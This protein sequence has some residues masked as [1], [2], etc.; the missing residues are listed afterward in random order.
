[1]ASAAVSHTRQKVAVF[2]LLLRS[3]GD[4]LYP[5][6]ENGKSEESSKIQRQFNKLHIYA[7]SPHHPPQLL[8]L[9][10]GYESVSTATMTR[11]CPPA[12]EPKSS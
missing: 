7:F 4:V 1:M 9:Q 8:T 5:A 2:L 12:G 6:R 11:I 10:S 3:P